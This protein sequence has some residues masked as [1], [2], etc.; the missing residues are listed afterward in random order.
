MEKPQQLISLLSLTQ[1]Y[2][3]FNSLFE[4]HC[5]WLSKEEEFYEIGRDKEEGDY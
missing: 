4:R 3:N 5:H 2:L 1:S